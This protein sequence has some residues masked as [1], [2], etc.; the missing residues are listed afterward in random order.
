MKI[1]E[2]ME[3]TKKKFIKWAESCSENFLVR[4]YILQG[5]AYRLNNHMDEHFFI[6]RKQLNQLKYMDKYI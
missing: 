6:M 2:N 3:Y 1:K 5:E 4:G